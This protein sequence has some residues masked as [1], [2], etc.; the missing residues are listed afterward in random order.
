MGR[1][2]GNRCIE[3]AFVCTGDDRPR[4]RRRRLDRL[5]LR[6]LALGLIATGLAFALGNMPHRAEAKWTVTPQLD[7]WVWASGGQN[8]GG[9][10]VR[11]DG[12]LIVASDDASGGDGYLHLIPPWGAPISASNRFGPPGLHPYHLVLRTGRLYVTR[13]NQVDRSDQDNHISVL[14][15][16]T[17]QLVKTVPWFQGSVSM[18][19]AVDPQGA[20]PLVIEGS[21]VPNNGLPYLYELDPDTGV[22]TRWMTPPASELNDN[23]AFSWDGSVLLYTANGNSA[24]FGT[25]Y[26]FDR[27]G[28]LQFAV[29]GS[30][31]NPTIGGAVLRQASNDC[32]GSN[33]YY[34]SGGVSSL[35]G[36]ALYQVPPPYSANNAAVVAQKPAPSATSQYSDIKLDTGGHL[37]VSLTTDV[38]VMSCPH[39]F[40]PPTQPP[41]PTGPTAVPRP[42]A[43]SAPGGQPGA[44]AP[45]SG[46]PPPGAAPAGPPPA[47]A[48]P[49]SAVQPQAASAAQQAHQAANQATVEASTQ[50]SV[51]PNAVG[52]VDVVDDSPAMS[53]S[54][55]LMSG[56]DQDVLVPFA[57]AVGGLTLAAALAVRRSGRE[58]SWRVAQA[59]PYD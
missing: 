37:V 47:A 32:F 34:T 51:A 55:A 1:V 7:Q 4:P 17:G 12:Y 13:W 21:P 11:P 52:V 44:V 6:R 14:D 24:G 5:R 8:L 35:D 45:Q 9:V 26:G 2:A 19:I 53:F 36:T 16:A 25:E 18:G 33:L 22:A 31:A 58:P 43:P 3:R 49:A 10:A 20:H 56:P 30:S 28:N 15:A 41:G 59:R 57:V 42:Q 29:H 40:V 27:S 38:V 46:P 48:Q 50:G 54:A 23:L 39:S